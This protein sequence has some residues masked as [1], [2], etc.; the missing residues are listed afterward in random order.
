[1]CSDSN[2]PTLLKAIEAFDNHDCS[3]ALELLLPLAEAG[4]PKAQLNLATLYHLGLGVEA[5]AQRAVELYLAVDK[6]N[7]PDEHLFSLAYHNLSTLYIC[8]GPGVK[9]SWQEAQKYR[10]LSKDLGFEM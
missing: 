2:S 9:P 6:Q 7:I 4:N 1:M 3:T 8:G 5:D 10:E